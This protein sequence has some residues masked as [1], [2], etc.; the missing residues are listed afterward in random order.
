MFPL[1]ELSVQ[2]IAVRATGKHYG[3]I[4]RIY[5]TFS[6]VGRCL[7]QSLTWRVLVGND[8]WGNGTVLRAKVYMEETIS[9]GLRQ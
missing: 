3:F 2:Q 6:A 9:V 5:F 7:M 1:K 4:E 8:V